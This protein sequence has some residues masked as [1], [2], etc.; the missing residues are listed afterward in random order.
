MD[1]SSPTC[2]IDRDS[3]TVPLADPPERHCN[4]HCQFL[5][6]VGGNSQHD[7]KLTVDDYLPSGPPFN[8]NLW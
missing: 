4:A 2:R 8:M 6:S 3:V 5:Q 1:D 7:G